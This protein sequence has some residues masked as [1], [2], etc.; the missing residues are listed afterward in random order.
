MLKK[1]KTVNEENEM[2]LSNSELL[3]RIERLSA[4]KARLENRVEALEAEKKTKKGVGYGIAAE[5]V[6]ELSKKHK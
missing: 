5:S 6:P 2:T 3:D 4:E 1:E